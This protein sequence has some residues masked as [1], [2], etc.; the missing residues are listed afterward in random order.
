MEERAGLTREFA[1]RLETRLD[2]FKWLYAE[3]Y[4]HD[5]NAFR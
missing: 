1:E 4:H 3:L 2:E 5:E